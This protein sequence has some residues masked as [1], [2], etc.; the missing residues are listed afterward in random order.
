MEDF[1]ENLDIIMMNFAGAP[2]TIWNLLWHSQSFYSKVTKE[3]ISI[4]SNNKQ[5]SS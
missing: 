4:E 1:L 3:S 5:S 2:K